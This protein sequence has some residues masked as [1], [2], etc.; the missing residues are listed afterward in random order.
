MKVTFEVTGAPEAATMLQGIGERLE[1]PLTEVLQSVAILWETDFRQNFERQ[2][3]ILGAWTPLAP[4]T[5]RLR[6]WRGFNPASPILVRTH[7]LQQSIRRLTIDDD[8]MSVG[9]DSEYAAIQQFGGVETARNDVPGS[10]TIPPRPFVVLTPD[11]IEETLQ[12]LHE[13]LFGEGARAN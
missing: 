10:R 1:Q 9:S 13:F 7:D 4:M 5:Q 6:K 8:S 12:T 2:G 3:S 11:L